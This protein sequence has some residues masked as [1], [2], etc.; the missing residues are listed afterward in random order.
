[1]IFLGI[2]LMITALAWL[3]RWIVRHEADVRHRWAGIAAHPRVTALRT[4]FAPRIAFLR[5]RVAAGSAWLALCL[6]AVGTFRRH[7]AIIRFPPEPEPSNGTW[8]LNKHSA[9]IVGSAVRAGIP[10]SYT[11]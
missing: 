11:R 4:R 6:T 2:L 8:H 5:A 10:L 7:R 9:G 3:W 1:M